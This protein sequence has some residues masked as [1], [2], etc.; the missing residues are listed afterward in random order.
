MHNYI[1]VIGK[2]PN[3]SQLKKDNYV[4]PF[5]DHQCHD[6][7]LTNT[8]TSVELTGFRVGEVTQIMFH[9]VPAK[10]ANPT[11][12]KNAGLTDNRYFD[13]IEMKNLKLHFNGEVIW[14]APGR[15]QKMWQLIDGISSEGRHNKERYV[16]KNSGLNVPVGNVASAS[17]IVVE[18]AKLEHGGV[19][20]ASS[21]MGNEELNGQYVW[22]RIPISEIIA[23]KQKNG[24]FQGASFAKSS[25]KLT[26][27]TPKSYAKSGTSPFI[28]AKR[29][30]AT[31]L[32]CTYS[33]RSAYNFG[34]NQVVLSY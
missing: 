32:F 13:G 17:S 2:I 8:Q 9:A 16:I 12:S 28:G 7:S 24:Y 18:G 26:F 14:S 1:F 30:I 6:Y 19:E 5:M 15:E 22:Y 20:T 34:K 29:A 25:I 23:E 21:T 27:D 33:Y 4:Y 3:Q 11:G 10:L 31:K